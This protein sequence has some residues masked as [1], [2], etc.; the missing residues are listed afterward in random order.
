MEAAGQLRE[1]VDSLV[2]RLPGFVLRDLVYDSGSKEIGLVLA[3]GDEV[4]RLSWSRSG[5]LVVASRARSHLPGM[6]A[7]AAIQ[8]ILAAL[9]YSRRVHR[10]GAGLS[11]FYRPCGP[12]RTCKVVEH[13]VSRLLTPSELAGYAEKAS[14]Y[15]ATPLS[16]VLLYTS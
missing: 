11:V 2:S 3:R 13:Y 9:G 5:S 6:D 7:E 16:S 10:H 1:F 12:A 14:T 4:L 15:L 8:Y